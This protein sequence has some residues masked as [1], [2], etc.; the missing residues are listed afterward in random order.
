MIKLRNIFYLLA[1][2]FLFIDSTCAP[3]TS[4]TSK[5]DMDEK[6]ETIANNNSKQLAT[7]CFDPAKMTVSKCPK[8]YQHQL[9]LINHLHWRD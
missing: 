3:A 4:P 2:A 1:L 7:S 5:T 6:A 9:D 8:N